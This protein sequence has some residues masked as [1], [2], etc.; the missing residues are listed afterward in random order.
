MTAFT[1]TCPTTHAR[2]RAVQGRELARD[3]QRPRD[4]SAGAAE[5][6]HLGRREPI[7]GQRVRPDRRHLDSCKTITTTNEPNVATYT[8]HVHATASRCSGCPTV[9]ANVDATGQFGQIDA[10]LWDI[11]AERTTSG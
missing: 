1:Q 5:D 6:V 2:R 8:A 3:P 7:G 9:T 10:R 4:A 11:C